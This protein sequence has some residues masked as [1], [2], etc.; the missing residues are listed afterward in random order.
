[1]REAEG[2]GEEEKRGKGNRIREMKGESEDRAKPEENTNNISFR[3]P[4]YIPKE[5]KR[6]RKKRTTISK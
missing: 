3:R 6:K 4:H 1:M 5:K 2:R